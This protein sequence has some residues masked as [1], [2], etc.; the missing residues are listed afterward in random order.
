MPAKFLMLPPQTTITRAWASRLAAAVPDLS[1]VVGEDR[2]QADAAIVDADAAFGTLPP[3]LLRKAKRLR[4]LQAPNAAPPAGYY[5]PEL[6]E[7]PVIVT[8]FREIFNDHIGA[9]IMAFVLAFARGLHRYYPQQL[10]REWRP[11]PQHTGIV[12]LPA[13]TALIV[14]VGG[15]GAEAARLAAAFGINVI[16]VDARREDKPP[17]VKELH[18]P[19]K[20][21][22]QL[23]RADFVILTVPHT[24]ATEGF[25]NRARFQRMKPSAFFINIGRGK[26]TRLDDL[27]AALEAG[28]IAGA[29]LDVFEQ[30]PLPADH[31]LWTM[32]GVLITPHTAGYGPY[33][34]DR[35]FEIVLDNCRRF[36][37]GQPLRN[38]VDKASWF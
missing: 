12:H 27:V 2:Q 21:D 28:D 20:L 35:R 33:L 3:E 32:P 17:G 4:W 6:I 26:T 5:Y 22:D 15:I 24:P 1:I 31:P 34:D 11:A 9:H 29:A 10:R 8:N 25:M 7:H 23:P 38:V 14:G 36:L 13:A 18:H 16:G 37:A 30:E 19:D